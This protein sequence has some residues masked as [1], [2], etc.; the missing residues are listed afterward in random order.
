MTSV[1]ADPVLVGE[2]SDETREVLRAALLYAA[3]TFAV[4]KQAFDPLGISRSDILRR[5]PIAVLR[6]LP[7]LDADA[8]LDLS[9][10]SVTAGS[11]IVDLETSSGTTGPRK[12]RFISHDDDVSDHD[13]LA[14]LF[15]VSG[16]GPQ[17]RVACLDT[18]PVNLM[19]SFTRAFDLLGAEEAYMFCAGPDFDSALS[20]MPMLDPTVIV[21][22]PSIL[23]RCFDTLAGL[24]A[25]R[26]ARA[27]RTVIY[28]GEPATPSLRSRL[29]GTL[30]VE[31]FGYY[32]ASETS[33]LG[34]ECSAHNGIHLFTDRNVIEVAPRGADG[35]SGEIVVT[36]LKQR[37]L[38]L[39]RYP[40][41]DRVEVLPGQCACGLAFPRVE[42]KGRVG[43]N[44]SVMGSKLGY[45][46]LLGAIYSGEDSPG[47]MQLVLSR[48]TSDKLTIVLP[49]SMR[50]REAKIMDSLLDGEPDLDFLV[51]SKYLRL[52]LSFVD[53]DY[54]RAS[55]KLAS[56]VDRR[57]SSDGR[58]PR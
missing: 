37:A 44:F 18:D 17:D 32:G 20:S 11:Q 47:P 24:Y 6:S 49:E 52:E 26:D 9:D 39:L 4:Y 23:E 43:D 27:L 46:P 48:E 58:V 10:E 22:V 41:G 21:T 19:A 2:V 30:D 25:D 29:E 54:F 45:R 12:R 15:A 7:M 5:D 31:G 8:F 42:V 56:V 53:A 1:R 50:R 40:L 38:P 51:E 13:F 36:T 16:V 3:A 28:V 57:E 35:M 33:A 55:R 14:R 34:I